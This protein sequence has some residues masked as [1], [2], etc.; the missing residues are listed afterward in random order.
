MQLKKMIAAGAMGLMMAGSTVGFAATL[1]DFPQPFVTSGG[2]EDFMIVVG[3]NAKPED[4]VAAIDLG[5]RL[6]GEVY[7]ADACA[8]SSGGATVSGEG[9]S[10]ATTNMKVYMNDYLKKTGARYIF[11]A[12][13]MATVLKGGTLEDST[14]NT[15]YDYTQYIELS[16]DFTVQ[17]AQYR[18]SSGTTQDPEMVLLHSSG[19]NPSA[20][21]TTSYVYKGKVVFEKEVNG[22][23]TVG[24][25]VELFGKDYTVASTTTFIASTPKLVIYGSADTQVLT[26]KETVTTTVSGVEYDVTLAGVSDADTIVVTVGSDTKSIDKQQTKTI[27]GLQ[28]YVDDVYYYGSTRTDNQAKVSFGAETLTLEHGKKAYTTLGGTTTNIDGTLVQLTTSDGKLTMIEIYVVGPKS[29]VDVLKSG[30]TFS[31]PI[32]GTFSLSFASVTP[33]LMSSAKAELDIRSSGDDQLTAAFT[34]YRGETGTITWAY[35]ADSID[36]EDGAGYGYVVVEGQTV[37]ENEYVIVNSGDYAHIFQLSNLDND[38]TTTG[39]LELTDILTGTRYDVLM[40]MDNVSTKVIDGQTYYINGSASTSG[41]TIAWGTS[42]GLNETG[43]EITVWPTVPGA[44]AE[45]YAFAKNPTEV[46]ITSGTK[47]ILPTGTVVFTVYQTDLANIT[48][49]T[50]YVAS[51]CAGINLTGTEGCGLLLGKTNTGGSYYNITGV[52][53]NTLTIKPA[54]SSATAYTEDAVVLV[55]EQDYSTNIYSVWV[56]ASNET[57]GSIVQM[58]SAAPD[59]TYTSRDAVALK[60]DT[61]KTQYIDLYGV[62][63]E[64]NTYGQDTVTLWYPDEQ[65]TMDFFVLGPTG[66]V[67]TQAAVAGESIKAAKPIKTSVATL[68]RDVSDADKSTYNMI[69]V[70]GPAVNDIVVELANADKTKTRDWFIEQGE[71]TAILDLVEDAFTTSKSALVAAG[72]S[73]SDTQ[74]ATNVLFKYD[75]NSA[76]LVGARVILKNGVWSQETA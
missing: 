21:L 53:A 14:L 30:D 25:T 22:T 32:F 36:M 46:N 71:G 39:T 10:V 38:G 63:A 3:Q 24:E 12:A 64:R 59:F 76:T 37:S 55:E 16:D 47:M 72:Y 28:V 11:T 66:V 29:T 65:A 8:G 7:T 6:G 20:A 35:D 67:S 18:P 27:G 49:D 73:C 40:G 61:Y 15:Q 4:V 13:D 23:S 26:E 54:G 45:R 42:S 58:M 56:Q 74:A 1:A 75:S 19:T 44:K 9:K 60:S 31:D 51:G 48:A 41:V 33:D 43:A 52:D 57:S 17:F 70:G 69:L 5:A 34:D 50:G 68:D 62:F 2:T